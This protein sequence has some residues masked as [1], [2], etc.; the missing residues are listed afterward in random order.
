MIE[1]ISKE[2]IGEILPL[3]KGYQEF[4]KA[5]EIS[6]TQNREFF[7]QFGLNSPYGCQF[8]YKENGKFIAFATLYFSFASTI[9]SKVGVMNDLYVTPENRGKGI[10]RKLIDHCLGY[11][12]ENGAVRLQW[13]TVPENTTAQKTYEKLPIKK[14][15]WHFYTYNT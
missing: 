9:A 8:G 15:T 4:Y 12:K 2:N 11:V 7:S 13:T 10:A 14:S 5:T 1:A 6:E 3:I